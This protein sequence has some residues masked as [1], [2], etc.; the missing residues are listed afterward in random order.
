MFIKASATRFGLA[1]VWVEK[2]GGQIELFRLEQ[3]GRRIIA[4]KVLWGEVA[5]WNEE[6]RKAAEL[7]RKE[8]SA[9]QADLK[10][11]VSVLIDTPL[12]KGQH[13]V[14][15]KVTDARLKGSLGGLLFDIDLYQ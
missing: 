9:G 14:K 6:A 13:T 11:F 2:E 4:R 3:F 1:A 12:Q 7:F 8:E 10:E 15:V 5:K